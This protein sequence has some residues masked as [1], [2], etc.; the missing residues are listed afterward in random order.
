MSVKFDP[1][2]VLSRHRPHP[3]QADGRTNRRTDG[4]MRG[5]IQDNIYT[6]RPENERNSAKMIDRDDIL[7]I[8]YSVRRAG[9]PAIL[10]SYALFG[11]IAV[12]RDPMGNILSS[13]KIFF[14]LLRAKITIEFIPLYFY[15]SN[16]CRVADPV[17]FLP[18][19]DPRIRS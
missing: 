18:N 6:S 17:R 9:Y 10:L 11:S 12:G 4:G 3:P 5:G 8:G 7:E 19:P 14:C 15:G 2:I 1:C 13:L 16:Q